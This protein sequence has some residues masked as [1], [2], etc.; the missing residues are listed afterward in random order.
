MIMLTKFDLDKVKFGI[1]E[2]TWKRAVGLYE[3]GKI[4]D[5]RDTGF[6]FVASVCGI[7]LYEVTVSKKRYM[8]G[9]CTCYLGQNNTLCKHIIAVAIYGLKKGKPLS[10][11]EKIQHNKIKFSRK[12]GEISPEK[13]SLFKAEISGAMRYI[14]A[15]TGP[16]KIWFAYQD[17]LIEGCNRL[18]AIFS[19]LPASRQTADLVIRILLRLDKKLSH[20]GVD[21]SDG[22]VGDFIEEAVDLLTEFAKHDPECIKAFVKLKDEETGFGWEDRLLGVHKPKS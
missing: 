10:D 14:K 15:Y 20:G 2:G 22:T 4:K 5:F 9:D 12:K 1:D 3:G 18:A 17:S 19:K 13:L 8:D 11:E 21:D 7:H 6:T 16:S